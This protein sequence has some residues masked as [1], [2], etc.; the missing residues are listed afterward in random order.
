MKLELKNVKIHP[1]MSEETTCFSTT[2]WVDGKRAASCRN[3][4]RGGSTDVYFEDRKLMLSVYQWCKDNPIRNWY[5]EKEYIFDSLDAR[6]DEMVIEIQYSK[7]FKSKEKSQL[8]LR[9][10]NSKDPEY[11]FHATLKLQSTINILKRTEKGRESLKTAV[12]KM[13]AKG[14]EIMNDNIDFKELGL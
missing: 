8:I 9:D 12:A 14:Y 7:E 10:K 1:D 3:D 13:R 6:V 11:I 4:G 2:L 5:R